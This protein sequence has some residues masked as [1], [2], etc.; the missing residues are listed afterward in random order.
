MR[1]TCQ[2]YAAA[3][4]SI[5]SIALCS[6][7]NRPPVFSIEPA[8]SVVVPS[9]ASRSVQVG[10]IATPPPGSYRSARVYSNGYVELSELVTYNGPGPWITYLGTT[11]IPEIRATKLFTFLDGTPPG[12]PPDDNRQPCVLAFR[13]ARGSDWQGCAYPLLAAQLLAELPVLSPPAVASRCPGSACQV[14]ILSETAPRSHERYG[15]IIQDVILDADG[16]FWCAKRDQEESADSDMLHVDRGHIAKPDAPHVFKWLIGDAVERDTSRR[17]PISPDK[18]ID[19]VQIRVDAS[20]WVPVSDSAAAATSTRWR[21][22][23][24]TLPPACNS[25]H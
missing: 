8:C 4:T 22:I 14:R 25:T 11:C 5:W 10:G 16:T 18:P 9:E 20:D 3:L 12:S 13:T 7:G 15:Q 6:C 21:Q 24:P 17:A 23:A 19:R 1:V 2:S